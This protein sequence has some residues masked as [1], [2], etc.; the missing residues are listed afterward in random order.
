MMGGRNYNKNLQSS[1]SSFC[2]D[3]LDYG[4]VDVWSLGCVLFGILH[5]VSPFEMEF[6]KSS[7]GGGN[8]SYGGD[9]YGY[10]KKMKQTNKNDDDDDGGSNSEQY[11]LVRI[12]ECT[13]LKILG[14]VPNPPWMMGNGIGGGD[15][16][17]NNNNKSVGDGRDGRYSLSMYKFIRYMIQQDRMSRPN[18]H[19]V[20][21]RFGELYYELLKEEWIP[22]SK[23]G[24]VGSS[25]SSSNNAGVEGNDD[26]EYQHDDFD[27]LIASRDFV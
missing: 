10:G 3:V 11:G 20:A 17:N 14:E 16:N 2:D 8:S 7:Y 25:N 19:E 26:G 23:T 13:T 21:K 27:S 24:G 5:G 4:K 9:S 6:V 15:N 12:V 22:Y 1:S 18:I